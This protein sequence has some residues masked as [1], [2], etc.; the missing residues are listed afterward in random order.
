[1]L[2]IHHQNKI[3]S[4]HYPLDTKDNPVMSVK[5]AAAAELLR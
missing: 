2:H 5:A 4:R 3:D 1:M